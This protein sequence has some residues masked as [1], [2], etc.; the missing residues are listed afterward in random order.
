MTTF[1]SVL[2]G[3]VMAILLSSCNQDDSVMMVTTNFG[4][5]GSEQVE[6]TSILPSLSDKTNRVVS[7]SNA[8]IAVKNIQ[9]KTIL[10]E[11]EFDLEKNA[12]YKGPFYIDLLSDNPKPFGEITLPDSGV[13]SFRMLLHKGEDLPDDPSF[14][15]MDD[16]S[17]FLSATVNGVAFTFAA[18]YTANFEIQ[19][20]P[21]VIPDPGKNLV[22]VIKLADLFKKI[23]LSAIS[24]PKDIRSHNRIPA[25]DPCPTIEQ[26]A[27][28][29]YTCFIKGLAAEAKLKV[30]VENI[31]N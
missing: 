30:D 5:S 12:H 14:S 16:N 24:S 27:E 6:E 18:D 10:N 25:I 13:T 21:A 3:V 22:L 4:I 28:D 23:N 11:K 31:V 2:N 17:I 15:I 8:F 29:L 9:F 20:F 1:K 26:G 19:K 7:V